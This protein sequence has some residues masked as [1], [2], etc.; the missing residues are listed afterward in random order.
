[1]VSG[2]AASAKAVSVKAMSLFILA[3]LRISGALPILAR[4]TLTAAEPRV[5]HFS[6]GRFSLHCSTQFAFWPPSRL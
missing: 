2:A 1:L 5:A 6:E 4:G 3:P